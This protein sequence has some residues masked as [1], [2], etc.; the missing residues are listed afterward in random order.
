MSA[1]FLAMAFPVWAD[2]QNIVEKVEYKKNAISVRIVD[3]FFKSYFA[4]YERLVTPTYSLLFEGGYIGAYKFGQPF[5][6]NTASWQT[7]QGYTLGIHLRWHFWEGLDS[8]FIGVF[9]KYGSLA[10]RMLS[11]SGSGALFE[12]STGQPQ[13]GFSSS[14][15][16]L[17]INFGRRFV[18]AWGVTLVGRL[19]IG[20]NFGS[21]KYGTEEYPENRAAFGKAF[22]LFLSVDAELSLGYVF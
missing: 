13:V 7:T 20:Y 4:S 12:S 2:S 11:S 1:C 22:D 17:G 3:P 16:V 18:I 10:G 5:K 8:P 21:I 15:Q 9:L 14:Y 19:G 6:P